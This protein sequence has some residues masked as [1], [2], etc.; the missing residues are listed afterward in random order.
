MRKENEMKRFFFVA[1]F[2]IFAVT[3]QSQDK[4][5]KNAFKKAKNLYNQ[6]N[7]QEAIPLLKKAIQ[8]NPKKSDEANYLIGSCQLKAQEYQS[9]VQSF[10]NALKFRNDEYPQALRGRAEAYVALKNYDLAEA[11]LKKILAASPD[12]IDA[13]Y[14]MGVVQYQ[15]ENF[16]EASLQLEKVVTARPED[17]QAHYFIGWVY[18]KLK[19]YD[20]TI[21]HF[22][23]YVKLCPTCP[24]AEK[25]KEI[26]RSLKG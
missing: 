17:P 14:Q 2:L 11:D 15:K 26:L 20:L 4:D 22:E 12:D 5:Q 18:Y 24:E 3:V 19:K 16:T 6:G 21:R 25:I 9:S 23:I 1:V 13:V 8:Q 10:T 7:C